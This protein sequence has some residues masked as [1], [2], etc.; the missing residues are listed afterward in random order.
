[1]KQ[2]ELNQTYCKV[3]STISLLNKQDYYPLNEGVYKI[4]AGILDD[5][6]APFA[7]LITFATLTS[8]SSKKICHLTLMLFK[9]G[10]V[11]KVFDPSSKKLYLRVTENG[12]EALKQYFS[13]HKMSFAKRTPKMAPTIVKIAG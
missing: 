13:K 2:F 10:L 8:F 5:E 4:L 11:G 12:E 6:T 7:S 3:L 1:M 9:H